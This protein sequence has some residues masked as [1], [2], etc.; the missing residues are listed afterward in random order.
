MRWLRVVAVTVALA[1]L[2]CLAAGTAVLYLF[3]HYDRGLP[4]YRRLA[5]YQPPVATRVYAADGRMIA[6]YATQRRLFV[7]IS[8]IP[9]VV[10]HAVLAAEDKNFY[11]HPGI[12]I[13]GVIRAIGFDLAHF[14][15][16]R[17][18]EGASTITQQVAKVF[19]LNNQVTFSRKVREAILAFRIDHAFTKQHILELYLNEIYLGFGAYGVAEAAVRYF[20]KSLDQL[21]IAQAAF[22]GALPKGPNNYNPIRFPKRALDRRDWV[23]DRMAD[24]GFITRAQAI[25]AKAQP[26]AI[27]QP[28]D[29]DFVRA[30]WFAAEVRRELIARYGEKKVYEGGLQVHTS[31]NPRLQKIATKSLR[32]GLMRYDRRHG[33]RGPFAVL[34]VDADWARRLAAFPTPPGLLSNW[35]LAIV[36]KVGPH[37]AK[38]G[39]ADGSNGLIPMAMMRWA[40]ACDP[41]QILGPRVTRPDQ[42]LKVGDVIAVEPVAKAKPRTYALKQIPNVEGAMVVMNPHT[43]QVLSVV[44]GWDFAMSQFDRATQALRQ[45]GSA[46][47][48]FVYAAALDHGFTPST[49]VMDA[50]IAIAQGPGLPLWRPTNYERE[51]S[52]PTTVR[53]ALEHS[54]NV[55]TVRIARAVG[56]PV[57]GRYIERFGILDE[58]PDDLSYALGA[59]STSLLRLTNAYSEL[60]NGGKKLEP[61]LIDRIQ[62]R[63]GHTIYRHDPRPCPQC[64]VTSWQDQPVPVIP[65][66]RP[67]ILGPRTDYQMISMLEGVI[68]RG[69]GVAARVL[70]RPVAG[71]TGT[72]NDFRDAW[73]EGFTPNLV[74][75]TYVG[76]DQPRTLGH[77]E[78]AARVT[79]PIFRDFMQD[80][81]AGK[82]AVPFRVP[83]GLLLVRVDATSGQPAPPSDPN[84]IFEAFRPGTQPGPASDA[85]RAARNSPARPSSVVAPVQ[86]LSPDVGT[87]GLY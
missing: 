52:G 12:D 20:N 47:K 57:V 19:L 72:T 22:L 17:R 87:G 13:P 84:A 55:V 21:S 77:A 74:D 9:P 36:L 2:V 28:H 61:S 38:I 48:P 45:T 26:L 80:A 81:L 49:K 86:N 34:P 14:G 25:A 1:V 69:T 40:R 43:G 75:G 6:E 54:I 27:S 51:F 78:Q 4:D 67:R 37:A 30:P 60:A 59:G 44:G 39:F 18:P 65:D 62:D 58:V 24:D 46:I 10:I 23:I 8:A 11:S 31:L 66:N 64:Q 76:F 83:P 15:T 7:P 5:V 32:E 71:K 35:Q 3:W 85:V 53:V 41:H 82:P 63:N 79:V 42:V 33:W 29:V 68:Q 73:F 16:D 70:H 50:P 56:M